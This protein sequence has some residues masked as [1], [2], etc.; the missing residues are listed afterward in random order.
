MGPRGMA[1]RRGRR[2]GLVV[3]AAVGAHMANKNN[4]DQPADE[5]PAQ[6]ATT[7]DDTIAKLQQLAQ[8][9]DSGALTE[10]EFQAQKAALLGS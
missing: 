4:N 2:R 5:A 10:E 8:L 7:Q 9:R 3:G 1:R 6:S